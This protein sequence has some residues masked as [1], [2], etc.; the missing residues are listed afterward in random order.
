M[1]AFAY[2]PYTCSWWIDRKTALQFSWCLCVTII[3][4]SCQLIECPAIFFPSFAV[5][6]I[7][8]CL[9]SLCCCCFCRSFLFLVYVLVV[10]YL[11]QFEW[12]NFCTCFFFAIP[13]DRSYIPN[14][15]SYPAGRFINPTQRTWLNMSPVSKLLLY[16]LLIWFRTIF[17]FVYFCLAHF[18]AIYRSLDPTH[19]HLRLTDLVQRNSKTIDLDAFI[20]HIDWFYFR[21]YL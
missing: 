7:S 21:P 17:F 1:H 12:N 15:V 9:S 3:V 20:H 4:Q 14:G 6:N 5:I 8:Y 16:L 10:W 11:Y 13:I 18:F 19:S 2:C